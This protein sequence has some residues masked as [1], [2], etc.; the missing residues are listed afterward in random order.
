MTADTSTPSAWPAELTPYFQSAVTC[1][2]A[3]LTRDGRPI[4]VPITPYPG[5]TT[6]DVSTG[7]T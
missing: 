2:Y 7:L 6:L 3:S 4:T 1:E 5:A